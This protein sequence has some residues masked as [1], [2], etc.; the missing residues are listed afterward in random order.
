MAAAKL[1]AFMVKHG[2][3][4][5]FLNK[6]LDGKVSTKTIR[7]LLRD[8]VATPGVLQEIADT[9]GIPLEELLN[10]DQ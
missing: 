6:R 5:T 8:K 7:K 2:L 1:E 3:N 4:Q 9:M 10:P